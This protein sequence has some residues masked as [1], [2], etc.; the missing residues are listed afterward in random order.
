MSLRFILGRAGSGKTTTCLEEVRQLL[1]ESP[2]G[3][4][5]V[6]LVPEQ[7][8]FQTEYALASTPNL[9]GMMRAQVL[10][11][12]R[13]AYRVLLEVGGAARIPLGDLGQRMV[14]RQ[15]LEQRKNQLRVFSRAANQTGF[16]NVLAKTISEL[17]LYCITPEIL[18]EKSKILKEREDAGRLADK[19]ADLAHLYCD[20]EEYLAGR[21]IH[22]DDYLG[23]LAQRINLSPTVQGAKVWIDSFTGFTPQEYQVLAAIL[24]TAERV[25]VA[26]CLD[27]RQLSRPAGETDI[28]FSTRQTMDKL[29]SLAGELGVPVESPTVLEQAVP[30]RFVSSPVIG[31]LE[32]AFFQ[33]PNRLWEK[34]TAGVS[35]VAAANRR[36]EVEGVARE[37]I[38]LCRDE[39][40]RW[41]EIG[42]VLR[43][44]EG[45]RDLIS[46]IFADY[47]IAFFVDAKRTVMFHPLAELIRSA[48]EVVL[49]NWAYDP[50]FRYLKTDLIPL[51]REEV[52]QLENYVLA[53]G[54]RGGHWTNGQP[55][56]FRRRY[57]LGEDEGFKSWEASQLAQI[58]RAR[59]KAVKALAG[60][61]K[62]AKAAAT[63]REVS[64]ALFHLLEDLEVAHRLE[65]WSREAEKKGRLEAAREH[66]QVWKGVV[67][68]LDQM[69]EALGEEAIS[70]EEYARVL[71]AGLE[72]LQLGL[73]PP[74][75][76]Q[77][78]VGSL[79]RSRNPNLR[80]AFV[81]GVSDGVF[82]A[83]PGGEGF[84][85][86]PERER[87]QSAGLNLAPDGRRRLLEEQFLVYTALTRSSEYLW[88]SYPLADEEGRAMMPST[89]I[90]RLKEILPGLRERILPVEPPGLPAA[91]LE[92]IG[93]PGRA[94]SH[95]A[96]KLREAKAGIPIPALWWGVYNWALFRLQ[97]LTSLKGIIGGLFHVNQE[98]AI[99]SLA[100]NLYGQRMK[101]SVSRI[102][103]FNAC[104]F[105]HFMSYG[106]EL[107]DRP[108]YKLAAPDLGQF[109]H[110]ALKKIGDRIEAAGLDWGAIS[111]EQCRDLV[112]AVTE[113]LAPQL[114][115]EILLSTARYRYLQNKLRRTLERSVGLLAE[116]ARRGI[117]RPVGLEVGFG[118]GH[119]LPPLV[120]NTVGGS[121]LEVA[122]RIDR[123]DLG[124]AGEGSRYLRVI[125]Y[126]S[127]KAGLSLTDIYHGLEIQLLTYL[128]VAL[129]HAPLLAGGPA[130]PGA[131]LYFSL[132]DPLISAQG[133]VD[134]AE[135]ERRVL[136]SLK[137]KGLV[138]A[139]AGVVRMMDSHC[140]NGRSELLPVALKQDGG[141]YK[142][143]AVIDDAQF[144][145]L[146]RHLRLVLMRAAERILAGDVAIDPY[147]KKNL[148]PCRYCIYKPVC[149]HDLLLEGNGFRIIKDEPK[150]V[151]W[152]K[153]NQAGEGGEGGV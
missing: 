19:L 21:Y 89:V 105:A 137:T 5:L 32:R 42:V 11:F 34:E 71:L 28:F 91:D 70:L 31:H 15:L 41:R 138:L 94:L 27:S 122:G 98:K 59:A 51:S 52:D 102:E 66:A 121:A 49:E 139:D 67:D 125:D 119:D 55:W 113:E 12:R 64:L 79:D 50:V 81:L 17:K 128:D 117:F 47:G 30:W 100:R 74:G 3:N 8:T 145:A 23:L 72:S 2:M 140:L 53:H 69:V 109:F 99:P 43:D 38:R 9:G 150:E 25:S 35:L 134:P 129:T 68:L 153:L 83:R 78:L 10:S 106:L 76:D 61:E 57:T 116:H 6:L 147:R 124:V 16:A 120:L 40:Y 77:V 131:I 4:S 123:I 111:K 65:Q 127:G 58:N 39:G 92:F 82:P 115:N 146:R 143:S 144:A 48:L 73:I 56:N 26:L 142:D 152:F 29:L 136:A 60:F 86:E 107:K 75:L 7:A 37:V 62:S 95:L 93:H 24:Q 148:T 14:L 45:Y 87:L 112:R 1:Q 133:P 63:V 20:L 103:K 110:A 90:A 85:S 97:H 80:A 88:V 13:L 135:A 104:P 84:F 114:Q 130:L 101:V 108:Q 149:Q 132:Q 96:V 54:I 126:K 151:L 22:P 141:F 118:S 44:V 33:R 36:A 18:Q 46:S